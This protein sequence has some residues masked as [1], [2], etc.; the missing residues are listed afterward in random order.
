MTLHPCQ[1]SPSA[2]HGCE[3]YLGY[4]KELH[5]HSAN[6]AGVREG[7]VRSQDFRLSREVTIPACGIIADH[8]GNLDSHLSVPT[9]RSAL[10]W[11]HSVKLKIKWQKHPLC[12][13]EKT[14]DGKIINR[15]SGTSQTYYLC[16]MI[17]IR[18]G[19]N[20]QGQNF[21]S[22]QKAKTYRFKKLTKL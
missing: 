1:Q 10:K 16:L 4:N 3:W 7:Q 9:H 18:K 5:L 17:S 11:C 15:V 22:W 6:Q 8:I 2:K 14:Q 13:T 21:T 20:W 12:T 19:E